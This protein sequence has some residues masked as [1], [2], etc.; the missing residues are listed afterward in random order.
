[1]GL[2]ILYKEGMTRF[3][4]P[5]QLHNHSKYSLLDAVPSPEEWVGWC[6]E[7]GTPALAVTDHGTAISMYDALKAKEFI[8]NYNKK[9]GTN[10]PLD[11]CHLVPAVELYCKLNA[12][13]KSH[14]HITA[15]AASTEGY[16]NLMKLSSLAYND[17]VSFFGSVKARVTFDQINEYK[18]GIKFGTGCIAGPIGKA[19]WEGNKTLAEERFLMYKEMFGDNLYVEFHCND[20]T[21]NFNKNTG[22]FDPIPA[23]ECSCDG[24]KQK[25]YNL[26][27]KD[28]VDKHGGKCIPVTDAHFIMPEDKIIQDCLLKNGNSN[29]WYFY[30][31]YHQLRADT[32]FDKLRVHLGDWLTEDKFRTWIRNTYEVSDA[33]KDISVKYDYHLPRVDIPAEIAA[34]TPDYN[35]QTYYFMMRLINEHGRWKDDPVY[36]AR[37]KQELDVIMKNA[38]LNFIPYFLVYEDIGRFARSQGILQGI[39]R[40]SAGGSLLSYYLKIIHVDPIKANLPFERFLS[41][42]RI[43]AGSFPDIDADI[44]DRAR[45]LIMNYLREKYKLGF[46]QIATFQK[47]K[48]KNAIKDAMFALYGRNRNDAEIKALCDSIEDS[49]QGVDEHDFLYGYTDNEG[50][51]NAGQV[52]LNKQLANFFATYPDVEKMV[53]KLIGTIRGWSRHASAFVISTLDLSAERVPTMVM[54]DKELGDLTCTQYDAGMVEKCGLVKADILGIKTLTAVSDCVALIKKANGT[55]YLEEETGVPY[56][57]RLPED[58]GVYTDFY[59]KDTDSSFQFNT[60]LIKG[61]VQE[62]CPTN[63]K[64]LADFT[65]LARPGALDFQIEIGGT[66]SKDGKLL[67][68]EEMSAAELYMKVKNGELQPQLIH[69]DLEPILSETYSVAV[70]QEQIMAILKDIGDFSGE[71]SDMIRSAIAKKKKD[72]IQSTF[73]KLRENA[74]KRNWTEHEADQLCKMVE[75]FS[76]YSFNRSHSHAYA[77]LGYITMYLKHH[78]P[79]EWWAS[80]LNLAI[81][82]EDKMRKSIAK[83]GDIVHPPSLKYPSALFE[84]REIN[85][86]KRIV[87]PISA[88]KGVGPA[89]VK[90]LCSKGP[91]PSVEDFVKRIDHAR[92]NSGGISYL[93][94]GRA[95]DDM[96]DMS[97]VDYSERRKAFIA[98]YTLLRGKTIKLQEDV[99]KYDPLSIFLME[100]EFNRAF[101]KHLLSDSEVLKTIKGRW[102]ALSVTGRK[103][104]PLKMGDVPV[105]A[106]VKDAEVLLKGGYSREVGMIL[107]YESSEFA[108]GISKKSGREWKKVSVFLSDGFAT[109]ECIE[110]DR[111]AALGWSKNSIVYVRGT[112]KAG[113][114]TPVNLQIEEIECIE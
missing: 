42:A 29:G 25:G 72:V 74:I 4:E 33:A 114:K 92:V 82:D 3:T 91:F 84:V 89:V 11:A 100:K 44:G 109:M 99:F 12:E 23:D 90:E 32:M 7:T 28:M 80:I 86:V 76:R 2:F 61:M 45:S 55:N 77:E 21:H 46:A 108:R 34:K 66:M 27:L 18:K 60:E 14:F 85:G 24:N 96:M 26:F 78:H 93:I 41:H 16:H 88:I 20:V 64:H 98:Q 65:A 101:N 1:M 15:W 79:L 53:N 22:S 110:W 75:A 50:N 5:A 103:N 69:K 62:F 51:Y 112:L 8:K 17:T 102:P 63:R 111:K 113:W 59:N 71:E 19:F 107:L 52:E 39:A 37:F 57:Y 38:T 13:D 83:L 73:T 87:T 10:H 104:L 54:K 40:G 56:I 105:I 70:Y 43:R 35:L 81:D 95:A 68:Q 31:S 58:P 36:V 6:L 47:M 94:K 9:H 97:I 48:T 67:N 30:E 49:Q 106:S